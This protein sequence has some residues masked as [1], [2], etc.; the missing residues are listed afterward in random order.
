M[1]KVAAVLTLVAVAGSGVLAQLKPDISVK[2]P[3]RTSV[4]DPCEVATAAQLRGVLD[5]GLAPYFPIKRSDDGEHVTISDPEITDATCPSFRI[6]VRTKIR[7]QRTQGFPQFSTSGQMRFRSPLEVR[8]AHPISIGAGAPIPADQVRSARACLTSI[9]VI[10]L[11]LNNVPNWLD[12]GWIREK[13]LDPKL[14]SECFDVTALVQAFIKS[15]RV[16]TA[17]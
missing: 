14:K 8:V 2:L 16:V 15:G 13:L 4:K 3:S 10:E 6:T 9:N 7:Y 17:S 5:A 1:Q 12:N 11:D